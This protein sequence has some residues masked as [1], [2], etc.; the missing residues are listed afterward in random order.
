MNAREQAAVRNAGRLLLMRGLHAAGGAVFAAV[1]PRLMGPKGYGQLALLLSLSMWFTIAANLGLTDVLVREAPRYERDL[2]PRG[3]TTLFGRLLAL[4]S[5]AGLTTAGL[6]LLA[7]TLWLRDLD[8]TTL[9]LLALTVLVRA[10]ADLCFALQLAKNR[11]AH[12]GVADILRLWGNMALMLPGYLL[13]GIRGAALGVL[14]LDIVIALVGFFGVREHLAWT[15]GG[16]ALSALKPHLRFGLLFYGVHLSAAAFDSSGDVLLRAVHG[17]YA[18]IGF[19]RVAYSAY[20]MGSSAITWTTF[21]FAPLLT[22]LYLERDTRAIRLRLESLSKWLGIACALVLLAA[23]LVGEDLVPLVFGKAFNPV[24]RALVVLSA[25]LFA[26]ALTSVANVAALGYGRGGVVLAA[27]AVQ[28]AA[29]WLLG[30]LLVMK[31]GWLGA[32]LG[33]LCALTAQAAFST[34]VSKKMAGYSL[35]PWLGVVAL[36]A[37]FLPLA[38]L[39]ASALVDAALLGV[40][41][42]GYLALLR[43]SGLISA[44]EFAAFKGA[45]RRTVRGRAAPRA[46]QARQ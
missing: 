12:W 45:L 38:A 15:R 27:S 16:P 32:A 5:L 41:V 28:L 35:R 1:V 14:V 33:I 24:A 30:P 13:A 10:P 7:T 23:V 42:V 21:A 17:D 2:D 25:G 43:V 20:L 11:A 9:A 22:A 46:P 4:R 29:F 18:S 34:F 19:L 26:V 6:Y 36:G 31:L 39:R 8:R 40:G 44:A 37:T 3:L